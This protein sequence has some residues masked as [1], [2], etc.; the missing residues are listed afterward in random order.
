RAA[1]PGRGRDRR[2]HLPLQ[3]RDVAVAEVAA[4]HLQPPLAAARGPP[5][6][7]PRPRHLAAVPHR[8]AHRDAR[9]GRPGA[10]AHPDDRPDR[11]RAGPPAGA[12]D[13][14]PGGHHRG[15]RPGGPC[16]A[17]AP[18]RARTGRGVHVIWSASNV[19]ALPAACRTYVSVEESV[20]GAGAGHVR[21]G[22]RFYPVTIETVSVEVAA[23]VARHL[24]PVI[25]AGVP[26]DDDSDLPR[27]IP[28]L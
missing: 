26:I 6:R 8:G 23:G 17:R 15:R 9:R 11:G 19:A 18:G 13:P 5:R 14:E 12:A 21:L 10:A 3:P 20:E 1:L 7:H 25:D 28:Y 2:D 16:P 27:S 24:A 22:E 4:A